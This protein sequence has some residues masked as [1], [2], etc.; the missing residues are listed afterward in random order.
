MYF[1]YFNHYIKILSDVAC[2]IT[3]KNFCHLQI[4]R[5]KLNV[6]K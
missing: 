4:E 1:K 3:Q 2:N 6:T 5:K